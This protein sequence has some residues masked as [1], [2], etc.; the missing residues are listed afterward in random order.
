[1]PANEEGEFELVL[2]NRQLL[3]VFSIIVAL[4]CIFFAIGYVVGRNVAMPPYEHASSGTGINTAKPQVVEPSAGVSTPRG[5][6]A[7]Q[8]PVETMDM[9]SPTSQTIPAGKPAEPLTSQPFAVPP[10][11]EA[12]RR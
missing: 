7:S 4:L 6:V 8:P 12:H 11:S 5:A 3:S 2:G 10:S 9:P 1:M